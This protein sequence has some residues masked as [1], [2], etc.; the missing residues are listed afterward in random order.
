VGRCGREFKR[1]GRCR[2]ALVRIGR[3][4]AG[5][6]RAGRCGCEP[7]R[8][9]HASDAAGTRAIRHGLARPHHG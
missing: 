2:E 8:A 9:L 7:V 6:G 5:A 3:F 1:V 4:R